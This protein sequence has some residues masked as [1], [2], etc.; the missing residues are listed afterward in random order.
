MDE[1]QVDPT[2]DGTVTATS[3][4]T[5]IVD[6]AETACPARTIPDAGVLSVNQRVRIQL[7]NPRPPIVQ[8]EAQ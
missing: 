1:Q 8:G 2:V 7:D 4:L 3:P 5:V 6:G